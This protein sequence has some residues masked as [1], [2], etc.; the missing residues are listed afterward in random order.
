MNTPIFRKF[1]PVCKMSNDPNATICRH[2]GARLGEDVTDQPPT[3]RRVDDS[4]ELTEEIK[5][6][7]TSDHTPPSRGMLLFLLNNSEP[8]A[9]TMEREF[10]LGRAGDLTAEPIVDLTDHDAFSTGVSRRHAMIKAI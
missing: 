4:F 9:L 1:C 6:R 5:E 3:T 7:I 8:I 10:V 2:C